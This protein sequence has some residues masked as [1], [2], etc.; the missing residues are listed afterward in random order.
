MHTCSYFI[1][2]HGHCEI[3]S[4]SLTPKA[5]LICSSVY[6]VIRAQIK[7]KKKIMSALYKLPVW[8]P[9]A[10]RFSY[11]EVTWV[12]LLKKGFCILQFIYSEVHTS[13]EMQMKDAKGLVYPVVN[14]WK[15][16]SFAA[17]SHELDL[18]H[19]KQILHLWETLTLLKLCAVRS[20]PH[21]PIFSK[22]K[23]TVC[24]KENREG[25]CFPAFWNS[26]FPLFCLS[27]NYFL[28]LFDLFLFSH[29][30]LPKQDS[31]IKKKSSNW[32]DFLKKS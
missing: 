24:S 11:V 6:M 29:V 10:T 16:C 20:S 1:L 9:K 7:Q 21:F 31:G 26:L 22:N 32:V 23:V 18:D 13:L 8:I 12:P 2:K 17:H 3:L 27:R 30:S 4:T 15:Q 25:T 28:D 5:G 14:L 19:H